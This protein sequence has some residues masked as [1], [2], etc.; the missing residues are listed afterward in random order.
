MYAS[1]LSRYLYL[2][3]A[4]LDQQIHYF[5]RSFELNPKFPDASFALAQSYFGLVSINSDSLVANKFAE[6]SGQY[7]MRYFENVVWNPSAEAQ[8]EPIYLAFSDHPEIQ[9]NLLKI[10]N[11]KTQKV[12]NGFH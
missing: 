7:F 12:K 4:P 3:K 11:V 5:Q 2:L 10:K 9:S 8:F 6:I 1:L